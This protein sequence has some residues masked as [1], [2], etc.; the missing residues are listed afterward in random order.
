[1]THYIDEPPIKSNTC[2]IVVTFNPDDGITERL[3]RIVSQVNKVVIV[4]NHSDHFSRILLKGILSCPDFILSE[5]SV[6]LGVATAL[7][8]GM[9]WAKENQ[10]KWALLFD[11][12]T[13]VTNTMLIDLSTLFNSMNVNYRNKIAVIGSNYVDTNS[14]KTL[15][16]N[17]KALWLETKTAITSGSLIPLSVY[18]VVGPFRDDFFID[19]VD[20]EYCLRA[21]AMGFTVVTSTKPMLKHTIGAISMHRLPWKITGTSNHHVV[22]RYFMMRN[23]IFVAKKYVT[24]EP[25]WVLKTL[26]GRIKMVVL[27]LLFERNK[28]DQLKYIILGVI[29]GLCNKVNRAIV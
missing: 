9:N 18:D 26:W 29:D 2:A 7:N 12:D 16:S 4:D 20:I 25:V 10:F 1:M 14:Q 21:R 23:F 17:S 24:K 22:R 28:S 19:F 3:S 5:N 27:I 11:Q 15:V 13:I 6:N 8:I